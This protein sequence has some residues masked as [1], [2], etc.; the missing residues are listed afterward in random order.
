MS[1]IPDGPPIVLLNAFPV[2][3]AQ[4][5]PLIAAWGDR[6]RGDVITFDMPG[7]G[8]MPLTEEEPGL[9]LIADAAVL[10]MREATGHDAA[11]WIGCSMGGYV[12]MA[13]AERSPDAVAGLGL[14]ATKATADSE[15]ALATREE[16]AHAAEA[17]GG[18]PDPHAAAAGLVGTEGPAR[19]ELV[20]WVAANVA[21]HSGEGIAWGQRA[22]A[23]RPD[24]TEVLR[25][26][27]APAVV[28]GGTKDAIIPREALDSMAA[29][30]GVD[31]VIVEGAG[32]LVALEAPVETASALLPLLR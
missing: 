31:P 14:I 9:E 11:I 29:A 7:I 15:E 10:A 3:R 32:H 25:A 27:D 13:V 24:R 2:D 4:W 12:A 1:L 19:E 23:A 6:V 5:E 8:E 26:V 30:L 28:V 17:A 16:A 21:R 22:M 18:A 20:D